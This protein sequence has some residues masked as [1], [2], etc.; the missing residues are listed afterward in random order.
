MVE[1]ELNDLGWKDKTTGEWDATGDKLDVTTPMADS[2][3]AADQLEDYQERQGE[4]STLEARR[5]D[6]LDALAKIKDGTYGTCEVSGDAI[7]ED[8]LE[9]NPA[10]RTCK[11]HMNA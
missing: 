11:A 4:T 5:K 3:E 9:A 2:N 6:V 7:E 1:Q 8:R 10:A